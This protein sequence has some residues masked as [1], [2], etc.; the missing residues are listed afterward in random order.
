MILFF[1]FFL[2]CF[3]FPSMTQREL[4]F[5]KFVRF[6][7]KSKPNEPHCHF[8]VHSLRPT[9]RELPDHKS[10]Y[11]QFPKVRHRLE[12]IGITWRL[13]KTCRAVLAQVNILCLLGLWGLT[14][15]LEFST[16]WTR[17]FCS[18]YSSPWLRLRSLRGACLF[19]IT[20]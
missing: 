1:F 6:S 12:Y 4:Q 11:C 2:R 16:F 14:V 3:F 18:Q 15:W 20:A 7:K 5:W 10:V 8:S 17:L 13:K 19:A 9:S